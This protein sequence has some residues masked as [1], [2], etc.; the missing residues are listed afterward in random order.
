MRMLGGKFVPGFRVNVDREDDEFG[1]GGGGGGG[2]VA[3]APAQPREAEE[4]PEQA[5]LRVG[6][7][8]ISTTTSTEDDSDDSSSA[9]AADSDVE[10]DSEEYES[11]TR[12]SPFDTFLSSWSSNET[13]VL[14]LPGFRKQTSKEEQRVL[15]GTDWES[16]NYNLRELNCE[17]DEITGKVKKH[18]YY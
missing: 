17:E 15:R 9:A 1:G 3:A 14:L 10:Q 8:S 13:C 7:R 4:I 2:G 16:V 5:V 18:I 12:E 6:Q 11:F